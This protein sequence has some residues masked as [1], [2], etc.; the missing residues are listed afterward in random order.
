M[1]TTKNR[2]KADRE[3]KARKWLEQQHVEREAKD[4]AFRKSS[5]HLDLPALKWAQIALAGTIGRTGQL[6]WITEIPDPRVSY[7]EI[8]EASDRDIPVCKAGT[9]HVALTDAYQVVLVGPE[10]PP[11]VAYSC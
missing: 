11:Y 6:L 9:V 4:R 5:P 2:R 10:G 3:R 1:P 8:S 7:S